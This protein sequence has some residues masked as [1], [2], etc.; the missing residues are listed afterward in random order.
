M[1]LRCSPYSLGRVTT[2]YYSACVTPFYDV[3]PMTGRIASITSKSSC[4]CSSVVMSIEASIRLLPQ[5][6]FGVQAQRAATW[7]STPRSRAGPPAGTSCVLEKH[8]GGA[9]AQAGADS[10][11]DAASQRS[12][13]PSPATSPGKGTVGARLAPRR[14]IFL[15]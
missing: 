5:S 9:A 12:P 4:G 1:R 3:E 14:C 15:L 11:A 10:R 2:A 7:Q 6:R 13:P 8:I